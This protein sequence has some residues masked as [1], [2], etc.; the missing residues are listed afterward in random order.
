L[1]TAVK[2]LTPAALTPARSAAASAGVP[3]LFLCE[4]TGVG[5]S[6]VGF[7]I[8]LVI[9]ATGWPSRPPPAPAAS[10]LR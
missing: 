1:T 4:V 3:V 2:A 9:S 8:Y 5:K 10:Q 6:T 7:E